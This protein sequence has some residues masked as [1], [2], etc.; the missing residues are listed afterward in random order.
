M[1]ERLG[2]RQVLL[3]GGRTVAVVLDHA[4]VREG[5][6]HFEARLHFLPLKAAA[7]AFGL[8]LPLEPNKTE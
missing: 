8:P 1:M 7:K 6:R 4:W 3:L 5:Q 2:L